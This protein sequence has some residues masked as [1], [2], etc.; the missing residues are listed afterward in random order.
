MLQKKRLLWSGVRVAQFF[1]LL[2]FVI[3]GFV[4]ASQAWALVGGTPLP[5]TPLSPAYGWLITADNVTP[6]AHPYPPVAVPN[7][8]WSAVEGATSYRVQFSNNIAFTTIALETTTPNTTFTPTSTGVFADGEWFWR[9]RVDGSANGASDYSSPMAF[10]KQWATL[11]NKPALQFPLDFS[12][13]DFYDRP[14]FSWGPV[15]GA[16]SYRIEIDN[17]PDFTSL[18]YSALTLA[19]WTDNDA[20]ATTHQPINK[21]ANGVYYWRVIPIDPASRNGTPSDVRQFELNYNFIPALVEPLDNSNP[22][23]TPTFRWE[24]VRGAQYYRLQYSTNPAFTT[25]MTQVDTRNTTWTPTSTIA[26]DVNYYWRVKAISGSSE[27]NWSVVRSFLKKWY[28]QPRLLLPPNN[29]LDQYMPPLFDWTPVPGAAKYK[30]Q[31]DTTPDFISPIYNATVAN[32]FY[33][34]GGASYTS[35][36]TYYWRVIP[37]DGDGREGLPSETFS[38]QSEYSLAPELVYPFMYYDTRVFDPNNPGVYIDFSPVE[39]RT[40]AYPLFVWHRSIDVVAGGIYADAYRIQV[41][42]NPNYTSVDWEYDT[43]TLSAVP[44]S[45]ALI[46]TDP[47]AGNTVYYWRVAAISGIGGSLTSAWSHSRTVRFDEALG[48]Y[49]TQIG[50][51]EL[52]RPAN[53]EEHVEYTPR[54]DWF[55]YNQADAYEIEVSRDTTFTD[56]VD[57][58]TV[59]Y[60]SYAPQQPYAERHFNELDFGTFYWRVRALSGGTPL[61]DWSETRRFQIASTSQWVRASGLGR[62]SS[63]KIGSD[64][65]DQADNYELTGLYATQSQGFWYFGINARTGSPDMTYAFYLDS[66]YQEGSGATTDACGYDVTTLSINRPEYILY[67][68]QIGNTFSA[69]N[70]ALYKWNSDGNAWEVLV[71]SLTQIGGDLAYTGNPNYFLEVEIPDTAIG[72]NLDQG[73][74]NVAALSFQGADLDCNPA[75]GTAPVDIVPDNA[76]ATTNVIDRFSAV[77]D[78]T[79]LVF[80]FNNLGGDPTT[81]PSVLPFAVEYPAGYDPTLL[82]LTFPAIGPSTETN[83]LFLYDLEDHT[84]DGTDGVSDAG[85][86]WSGGRQEVYLDPLFTTMVFNQTLLCNCQYYNWQNFTASNDIYGG[87]N[88][89]YW[90]FRTRF[91]DTA[92]AYGSWSE[93]YR[94][95]REGLIPENLQISVEFATPTFSW[96]IVE[97]ASSY[98]LIVDNDPVFASPEINVSTKQNTY[99][100]PNTLDNGTYYWKVRITRD[101]NI[102]NEWSPSETFTLSMPTPENLVHYPITDNGVVYRSPTFCWDFLIE[103]DDTSIP[104]LAA[105]KYRLQFS[106][107]SSFST[108]VTTV[109]T[110]QNCYSHT[111]G[112]AD[113]TYFWR[114]AMIDGNGRLGMYSP[115][116]VVTKQYPITDLIAPTYG[117][118]LTSTPTFEWSIVEGAKSYRLEVSTSATFSSI[119]DSVTTDNVFYT[120][121]KAYVNNTYYWRVAIIDKDGRLGPFNDAT[122]ILDDSG[123]GYRFFIPIVVIVN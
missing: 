75:P 122:I 59:E 83:T 26:N 13:I 49:P 7:F 38:Y 85:S 3:A 103:V 6:S 105:W 78:R 97:G 1:V 110:E 37:I 9:V 32:T 121:A 63:F 45:A 27:S 113:G 119:Y 66:D 62:A 106:L 61:T 79:Q 117:T 93:G 65:D 89:F 40:I 84:G 90:R 58:A 19:T 114:V 51:P 73:G 112:L 15:V 20:D 108:G 14:I 22:T 109:D 28:V 116:Q 54:F 11:D 91:Y 95:E 101:G 74:F 30:I 21:L 107:D 98:N 71:Q 39:D 33:T 4:P 96:N 69:N 8:E 25:N 76:G 87:D 36:P 52:I 60:P 16:S 10:T 92:E 5:P 29:Y 53:G 2:M 81:Y 104:V 120:P 72:F 47:L 67:V 64:Q 88:S 80:P 42:D 57:T 102:T 48:L 56:I 118:G 12:I 86:P 18:V 50:E 111:G 94:F 34:P 24:A 55:P 100:P 31:V 43:Q 77:T 68:Y 99:T 23:F 115:I 17:T 123:L 46:N 70:T 44:A 35:E 82:N 41:D